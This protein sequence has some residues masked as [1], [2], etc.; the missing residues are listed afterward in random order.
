M[1]CF[2]DFAVVSVWL[3]E[4]AITLGS[5][6]TDLKHKLQSLLN[7]LGNGL[8]R[9]NKVHFVELSLNLLFVY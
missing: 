6:K 3:N 5:V 4:C 2:Q 8:K 7:P 9:K 1:M